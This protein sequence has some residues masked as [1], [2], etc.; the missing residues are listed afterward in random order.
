MSRKVDPKTVK[1]GDRVRVGRE[2]DAD[3][4]V[5]G[6]KFGAVCTVTSASGAWH[7]TLCVDGPL[8]EGEGWTRYQVVDLE[9][10]KVAK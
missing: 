6:I 5:H 3:G 2:S 7:G 4:P 8:R 10:C 1:V 9:L